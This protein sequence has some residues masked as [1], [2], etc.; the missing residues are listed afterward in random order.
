MQFGSHWSLLLHLHKDGLEGQ[1]PYW[2]QRKLEVVSLGQAI[3]PVAHFIEVVV[4]LDVGVVGVA[5]ELHVH[6]TK[7]GDEPDAMQV[8]KSSEALQLDVGAGAIGV[9]GILGVVG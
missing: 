7:L 3:K 5:E 1:Q 2:Q 8:I 6:V 9:D 4:G